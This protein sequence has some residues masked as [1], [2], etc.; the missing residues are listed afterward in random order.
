MST[1]RDCMHRKRTRVALP[2]LRG[3]NDL[4]RKKFH[5][6]SSEVSGSG[7]VGPH[8]IH[9]SKVQAAIWSSARRFHSQ[10]HAAVVLKSA[11]GGSGTGS[12]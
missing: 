2:L 12:W 8:E 4:I 11:P 10:G 6:R 7:S 1:L 3:P 5:V 9:D